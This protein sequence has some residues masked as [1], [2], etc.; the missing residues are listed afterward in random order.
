MGRE[1]K[2]G[3]SIPVSIDEEYPL[4]SG[5]SASMAS[6]I[7]RGFLHDLLADGYELIVSTLRKGSWIIDDYLRREGI[8]TPHMIS[9]NSDVAEASKNRK[10]LI[11]DDSVRTGGSILDAYERIKNSC[12]SFTVGCLLINDEAMDSLR[13][14]GIPA[15]SIRTMESFHRYREYEGGLLSAGCQAYYYTNVVVPYVGTL[16]VNR[17][18]DFMSLVIDSEC[19]PGMDPESMCIGILELFIRAPG[20]DIH[21]VDRSPN[22]L[23]V[24]EDLDQCYLLEAIEEPV[25]AWEPD[26]CKLRVS[27]ACYN[28]HLEITVTPMICPITVRDDDEGCLERLSSDFIARYEDAILVAVSEHCGGT[29]SEHRVVRGLDD[30]PVGGGDDRIRPGQAGRRRFL[31]PVSGT[32]RPHAVNG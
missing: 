24:S 2:D 14:S 16:L 17:S 5:L 19:R 15:G 22:V 9:T 32:S 23:R 26:Q 27:A 21:L 8:G 3:F 25:G 18:P 10:V 13:D 29:R 6:V 30:R 31:R 28:G 7:I 4:S 12:R 20:A 11:F 1:V